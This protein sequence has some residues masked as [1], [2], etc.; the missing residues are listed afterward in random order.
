MNSNL[1]L[2]DF[3]LPIGAMNVIS[4]LP[5]LLLA[6]LIECVTTCYLSKNKI[7]LAPVKVISE[8]F[9]SYTCTSPV[10]HS[11][12]QYLQLNISV[13][14]TLLPL[15]SSLFP[16]VIIFSWPPFCSPLSHHPT[17]SILLLQLWAMHVQLCQFWWRVYLNCTGRVIHWWSRLCLGK[18]YKF[19]P[20]LVFSW[21]P[22]TSY[23]VSL[24]HLWPQH[25]SERHSLIICGSK[26]NFNWF[27][28]NVLHTFQLTKD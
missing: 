7:P 24:R 21:L 16:P 17:L 28:C 25:V 1:H 20:C 23:W 18:F 9:P 15:L 13:F 2:H 26:D 12:F 14:L 4:I 5:L 8:Y 3:L 11:S 6:P 19:H 22:S 10:K 27:V